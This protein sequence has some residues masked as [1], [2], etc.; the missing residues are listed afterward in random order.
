MTNRA[1]WLNWK[2]PEDH[3][4]GFVRGEGLR[5]LQDV[6]GYLQTEWDV[7]KIGSSTGYFLELIRPYVRSVT[8]VEPGPDYAA[9]ANQRGIRTV[10]AVKELD[11]AARYDAIFVDDVLEHM[12]QPIGFLGSMKSLL[13]PD[14]RL[15]IQVPNVLDVLLTRYNTPQFG[16]FYWQKMHYYYFSPRTLADVLGRAGYTCQLIP[17]QRYD[18]SNHIIWLRDGQPGGQEHFKD[19][20][21]PELEVAYAETLKRHWLCDT[22]FAIAQLT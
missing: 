22:I 10:R 8:G 2:T 15:F 16:A 5:R 7:L 20:F 12:R 13:K 3:F 4:V 1:G 6:A 18:L 21:S 14:S 19:I 11:Q 17:L 9:Y